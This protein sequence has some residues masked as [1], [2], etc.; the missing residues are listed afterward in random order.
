MSRP[1]NFKW[2]HYHRFR[3]IATEDIVGD[4]PQSGE[5]SWICSDP[6]G[7]LAEGDVTRVVRF[8]LDS[9]V[10]SNRVG[11]DFSGDR[12]I[13]QI[14]RGFERALPETGIGLADDDVALDLDDGGQV[15]LPF[16][17]RDGGGGVENRDR[18]GFVAVAPVP[19]HGLHA[20]Q[21][22]GVLA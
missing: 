11:R 14:D 5:N 13:G 19:V 18:A 17:S 2:T 6:R 10:L 7:V 15:R 12:P 16:R 3:L 20:G 21:G 22:L 4:A 1:P 9:P 8:V